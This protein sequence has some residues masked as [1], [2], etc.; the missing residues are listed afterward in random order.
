MQQPP[1]LA[2]PGAGIPEYQR[3]TGKYILLPFYCLRLTWEGAIDL[4]ESEGYALL[5]L[6]GSSGEDQLT[7]RVLVPP[8]IGLEDSSRFWSYAMVLEHLV[9]MGKA[10][11]DII[12]ELT[13]GNSR[14]TPVGTADLKPEGKQP[15]RDAIADFRQLLSDFRQRTIG[16]VG[17]RR[18][19]AR[20]PHPWFGSLRAK[21]W[22]SFVP[23]H[24]RI[25]I[26]Q[27]RR[28]LSRLPGAS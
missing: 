20:S 7:R 21:Q 2:P 10:V 5:A 9:I 28:I 14:S 6:A 22:I 8:Q 17:D 15:A 24:Q 18:N 25:H 27:A 3:L 23:F 1:S 4:L 12:V 11:A 13:H 19:T 16:D 26:R